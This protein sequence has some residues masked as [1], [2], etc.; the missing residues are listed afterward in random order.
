MAIIIGS[1]G[2]VVGLTA[3]WLSS[4]AMKK[5]DTY[6][7]MLLQRIRSEQ[8]KGMDDLKAKIELLEKKNERLTEQ[9][10]GLSTPGDEG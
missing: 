6:G 4:T 9:L 5:I 1:L 7:D 3:I 10:S 2:L 8:R